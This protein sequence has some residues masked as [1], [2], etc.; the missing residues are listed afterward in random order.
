MLF[1]LVLSLVLGATLQSVLV[2]LQT[3]EHLRASLR[4]REVAGAQR[5]KVMIITPV[6]GDDGHLPTVLEAFLAQDYPDY[7]VRF[8][9]ESNDEPAAGVV[10]DLIARHPRRDIRW[11]TA[12]RS[13][14]CGQKVHNLL[15]ALQDAPADVELYAFADADAVMQSNWLTLLTNRLLASSKVGA[16][17]G[18]RDFFVAAAGWH[19]QVVYVLNSMAA[20]MLGPGSLHNCIWGGSWIIRRSTF[21]QLEI[22]AAWRERLDDDYV[23][24]E[25]IV[26]AGLRVSYEPRI[27]ACSAIRLSAEQAA[28]FA[29]RQFFL[30]RFYAPRLWWLVVLGWTTAVVG[31]VLLPLLGVAGLMAGAAWSPL[32]LASGVLLYC[33]ASVR[34]AARQVA[35]SLARPARCVTP[36]SRRFELWRHGEAAIWGWCMLMRSAVGCRTQWRGITYRLDERGRVREVLRNDA[37]PSL[38]QPARQARQAA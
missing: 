24:T 15:M 2:S 21:E 1:W 18:Y 6:K 20:G 11:V 27:H 19:N 7:C 13:G 9:G 29:V 28:E 25:R 12:G 32:A 26:N 17:T 10:Q 4:G 34:A 37:Q 38:A 31:L 35:A 5:P 22:A 3:W 33:L 23:A 14:L 30:T 36:A 8:V 16:A